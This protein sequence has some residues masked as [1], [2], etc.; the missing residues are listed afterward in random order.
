MKILG[1]CFN[2]FLVSFRNRRDYG[3]SIRCPLKYFSEA[4]E[5]HAAAGSQGLRSQNVTIDGE[6]H[7][8]YDQCCQLCIKSSFI[9]RKMADT[10][11]PCSQW[12]KNT[13]LSPRLPTVSSP[14]VV[15]AIVH[16]THGSTASE[17]W[18]CRLHRHAT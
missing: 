7:R 11:K 6:D 15:L 12:E 13:L 10:K 8:F 3:K 1:G 18:T 17:S 9:W 2:L 5:L 4:R 16:D 14:T